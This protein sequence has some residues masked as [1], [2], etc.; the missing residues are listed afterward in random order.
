MQIRGY[1]KTQTKLRNAR[2]LL[3]FSGIFNALLI[4]AV[5]AWLYDWWQAQ[6]NPV[7]AAKKI[8]KQTGTLVG[9]ADQMIGHPD[10]KEMGQRMTEVVEEFKAKVGAGSSQAT[11]R[12]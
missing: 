2:R 10:A 6:R 7:R 8:E 1:G 11:T 4:A 12:P 9:M 3:T 5:A